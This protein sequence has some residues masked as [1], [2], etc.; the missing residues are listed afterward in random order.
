MSNIKRPILVIVIGYI[1]GIIMGLY[2]NFSIV[3][4]YLPFIIIYLIN[5]ITKNNKKS[6]KNKFKLVSVKRYVRY[7]KLF[8]NKRN[9]ILII[10]ISI[11]SNTIIIQQNRRYDILYRDGEILKEDAIIISNKKEGEY[12]NQYKIKIISDNKYKNTYLY[13]KANKKIKLEYGDKIKIK[14]EFEKGKISRNYGGFNYNQYLRTQKVHGI[15]K[16][17]MVEMNGKN[18]VNIILRLS[19][20]IK[21]KIE[22]QISRCLD[23]EE[24][25][26]VWAVHN[27]S[28]FLNMTRGIQYLDEV[29]E[30]LLEGF[31][32]ALENG[33]LGNEISM[34]L[35]F[36]L[37]DAKLHEDAVHRGPAQVLP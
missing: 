26:R 27:R 13:L 18:G 35:K 14:G 1:I 5:K 19:N 21:L 17:N 33:P 7:I 4:F 34:G 29:K 28:I 8:V 3:L 37:H 31:E 24:A 20:K 15:V 23:K 9:C 12:Q 16:A 10:I 22:E 25:R 2:F 11:I 30:L 32:S 36:K 6:V